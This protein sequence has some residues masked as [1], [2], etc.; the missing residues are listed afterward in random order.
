M[1]DDNVC[2]ERY[3]IASFTALEDNV[4]LD[5][6]GGSMPFGEPPKLVEF[7]AGALP[8]TFFSLAVLSM[9]SAVSISI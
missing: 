5:F 4:S 2:K 8:Q 3:L 6:M 1:Q 7:G 9:A